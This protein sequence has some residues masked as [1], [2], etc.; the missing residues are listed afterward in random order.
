MTHRRAFIK[1]CE[2]FGWNGGPTFNTRIVAMANGRERRNADWDQPRYLF[3]LPYMNIDQ[4]A[5]RSILTMFLNV[6]GRN[7]GFLY[8]NR[9]DD[10]AEQEV[11]AVA[12]P[13]QIQFQ[14]TKVALIDG[15]PMLRQVHA[16]YQPSPDGTNADPVDP[17][18]RVNG[19]PDSD[20]TIDHDQGIVTFSEP[21]AGGEVLDWSGR[22]SHWVRFNN[23]Q[24]LMSIDN[25]MRQ[26][27]AVG[28]DVELIE[29]E[30]PAEASS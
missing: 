22:F 26:G 8:R 19:A 14:L 6:R 5:Y 20:F 12:A 10:S 16:L 18:I 2:T 27:F 17:V 25:R 28:G 4:E 24:L 1:A 13:G 3:L 21:F 15:V 23:D 30:P 9:L 11:F 29:I 7:N